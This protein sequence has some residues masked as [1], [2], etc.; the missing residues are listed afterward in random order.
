[1]PNSADDLNVHKS[2][3]VSK[4]STFDIIADNFSSFDNNFLKLN[5]FEQ[6]FISKSS[7]SDSISMSTSFNKSIP[8]NFTVSSSKIKCCLASST[9]VQGKTL[10]SNSTSF[11]DITSKCISSTVPV[12]NTSCN[13]N[14]DKKSYSL[15]CSDTTSKSVLSAVSQIN[16]SCN[17]NSNDKSYS[18]SYSKLFS[19]PIAKDMKHSSFKIEDPLSLEDGIFLMNQIAHVFTKVNMMLIHIGKR[20]H[21]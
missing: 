10:V 3:S 19:K 15:S 21:I 6:P 7:N 11:S 13:I 18:S 16:T 1:M 20:H 2:P 8:Q 5:S 9:G 17:V 14:F 12:T 4:S